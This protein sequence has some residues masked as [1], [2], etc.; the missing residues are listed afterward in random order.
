[1][2]YIDKKNEILSWRRWDKNQ[3]WYYA[4]IE[5]QILG[6][7]YIQ[8]DMNHHDIECSIIFRYWWNQ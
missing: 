3:K 8:R 6:M 4:N 1:M 7:F 5:K 2:S